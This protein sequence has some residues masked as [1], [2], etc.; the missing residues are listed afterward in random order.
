M[1]PF[2]SVGGVR[3]R[4]SF[5]NL[6]HDVKLTCDMG[7]L[8]PVMCDEVMP[9]DIFKISNQ[10]VIRFQPLVAPVM[11]DVYMFTHYFFVPYRILWPE[12]EDF[13]TGGK[14]GDYTGNPPF[15][16]SGTADDETRKD[17]LNTLWDYFGFPI[18]KGQVLEQDMSPSAFPWNSYNLIWNE[19]YRDQNLDDEVALDNN[20]VLYRRWKKDYFTS[21]LPFQQRGVSPAF[22]VGGSGTLSFP[23]F[24]G[25]QD[26]SL[27]IGN[28]IDNGDSTKLI[29]SVLGKVPGL[30]PGHSAYFP[31][32]STDTT[33]LSIPQYSGQQKYGYLYLNKGSNADQPADS[34]KAVDAKVLEQLQKASIDFSGSTGFNIAD[35]RLAFQIQK[36]M[37]RNARSGVRYT[38]F[39][40]AHFGVS[41]TDSR[42]DRPEYIGG[43][44]TPVLFNEVLQTSATSDTSPQANMAGRGISADASYVGKYRV[45]EFGLIMGIMSVM[46]KATYQQGINRQWLRITRY[47]YPFPEFAHLSEQGIENQEIY[48]QGKAS[49]K[50]IFGFQ[51]RYNECRYKPSKV[52]GQ[53]RDTFDYWH[54]GRKFETQPLLNSSFIEC[55]P[56]KRPFAVQNEPGLL[57][58]FGNIIKSLRPIPVIA[59]PGLIDHF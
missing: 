42:L 45:Q 8:I 50:E 13:I 46:P 37:E 54:F 31:I 49:D 11:H 32:A 21:A 16:L 24:T 57:V 3:P 9:G 30:A 39:L 20:A 41:P 12:W 52:C 6:S 26:F 36:F 33:P 4:R 7:Q 59:E 43:T 15:Y 29:G 2:Q 25:F 51:G 58:N 38:E 18:L 34:I 19:Y 28:R 53:M 47:D 56:D 1:N 35:L 40:R 22:N 17:Q 44:R 27:A 14:D 55:K 23:E 48:A 5:F 10:A